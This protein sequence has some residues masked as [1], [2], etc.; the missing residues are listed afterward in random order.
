MLLSAPVNAQVQ[1]AKKV[2]QLIDVTL[3]VSDEN[4][5]PIP[6]ASVVIGEGITHTMTDQT[7]TVVFKGYPTDVVTITA[8][9]FE[10]NASLVTDLLTT[11]TVKLLKSKIHMT[12]DDA[13][14]MPFTTIKRRYLTGPDVV[15]KGS[16]FERYPSTDIRNTFVGL[17]SGWDIREMDGSPGLNSQEGLQNLNG[18]GN[19]F[20]SSDKFSNIPFVLVDGVPTEL[21]EAPI[22]PSEIESATLIKGIL[23]TA[24]YGPMA[25]GGIL[26]ITTKKGVK[27]E[28]M[29]D[30][31]IESGVNVVDRM[32]GWAD[33]N[34][35][36]R[37]N[38]IARV[39]SGLSEQYSAADIAGYAMNDPNSLRYPNVNF[40]DMM[41]KNSM[42]FNRVNVSSS[43]GNDVIQYFSSIGYAGEGDIYK[44]G[45]KSDYNRI[46]TRQN[47]TVKIND[48]IG[49]QFTFYGNLSFRRSPNYGY[50]SQ[51]TSEDS[52]SNP[53]LGLTEMPDVL[54][55]LRSVPPVSF[56]IYAFIDTATKIPWYGVTS[57]YTDNPIGNLE[58]QGYYTDRGRTGASNLSL[59]WNM[60]NIL[61]GL[62]STTFF[63]FNIHNMVRLG[64]ANDY[65]AYI[66]SITSAGID[67]LIKSSDHSYVKQ[68]DMAKLMDYYFQRFNFSQNF[69]YD[70][71]FG[72]NTVQAVLTYNQIKAFING[73]EEPQ[74]N[75]NYSLSAMY[76]YKDK[77]TIQAL[78]N[79]AGTASF[80]KTL[81][82]GLFPS[83]GAGWVISDEG[84]LSSS[85]FLNYLKL[86]AQYGVIG[87]ETYLS[88][89]YYIDRMSQNTSGSAFGSTSTYTQW[90][91]TTTD[92]SVPRVNPQRIGNPDITWEKRREFNAGFDALFLNQKLSLEMTYWNYLM[93]GSIVQVN[94]TLPFLAGLQGARP[95]YNYNK[96]RY[97]MVTADLHFSDRI[98]ELQYSIGGNA[99]TSKGTRVKYDEANYRNDYQKRTG[100][101]SDA[102]FGYVYEG[103]F[104]SDAETAAIPQKFDAQLKAGDL[105][106]QDLNGDNVV[107]D[108]DQ[109]VI[110]NSSPRLYYGVNFD[111]KYK[112]FEFYVMGNGR[113]FYDIAITNAYFQNGW[114]DNNYSDFVRNNIDGAY[115]RLTYYKVN[116]NF[117]TSAYWLRNGGYFKIQNV[118]LAYTIPAKNL[119]FI[120]GRAVRIYLRGANL[121]TLSK[122]KEVDPESINS[123]VTVYPLFR[124][125]TGGIKLNF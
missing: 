67:T 106:Y 105:K 26:S 17:T 112:N 1:R 104:A 46:N 66:P 68:S 35:Y 9:G 34:D 22:D 29:L 44:I 40:R 71:T 95:W 118:E 65:T 80:S 94:N 4:G 61:D 54:S 123:G 120:G 20:G 49:V 37:L 5:A 96:T 110:G 109:K 100:K 55:D 83:I 90:F 98:G 50:D 92:G 72:D 117:L 89:F 58:S 51:F 91:G 23:G 102:I 33:G 6:Q 27:N 88:P 59:N 79:Y 38:N 24:M 76:S 85:K 115:P 81:R 31:D 18:L 15:V 119:Q 7:G 36:V 77:Y 11:K 107:D 69:T 86:R 82:Y 87:N 84:F 43:G 122:I 3:K 8:P 93:D 113:A 13:V 64:K 21:T 124:T 39:N 116:N 45:S 16:Y 75:N 14:T 78:L 19:S 125:F 47:V 121:L 103:K 30:V 101:A 74:R 53:V 42:S 114:G 32:P 57:N 60:K 62:K 56:P 25:N 48:Q 97:N 108:L 12:S 111:L 28:R 63:G 70:K 99:T 2:R 41:L 10:K 52:G 73:I